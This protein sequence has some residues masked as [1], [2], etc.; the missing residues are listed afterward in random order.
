MWC[1]VAGDGGWGWVT[2]TSQSLSSEVD[3]GSLERPVLYSGPYLHG[4]PGMR[5]PGVGEGK[6]KNEGGK[7]EEEEGSGGKGERW[8]QRRNSVR[9]KA[10][11][12]GGGG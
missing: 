11:R 4:D 7:E 12:L 3:M 2:A 6:I 10:G 8:V 9:E 1:G 5:A